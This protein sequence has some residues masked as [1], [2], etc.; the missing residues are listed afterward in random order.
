MIAI[1]SAAAEALAVAYD[2]RL[3]REA[4]GFLLG[5][6]L[7]DWGGKLTAGLVATDIVLSRGSPS[8]GEFEIAD[9]ELR[10]IRAWSEDRRL[11]IVAPFHSH[12]SGDARPS[13]ADRAALRDSEWP[14]VIVTRPGGRDTPVVMTGYLPGDA[15]RAAVQVV[16]GVRS[17]A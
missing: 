9:F 16:P 17:S 14:W 2:K 15:G 5:I 4:C 10:R 3:P 7:G 8:H 1:S 6:R 12:P 11:H 13:A